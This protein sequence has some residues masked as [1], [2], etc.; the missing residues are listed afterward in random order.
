MLKNRRIVLV[1]DDEIMGASLLQRLQLEGAHVLWLK[2]M[3]RALG[4][5]RTPSVPIDAVICDIGLPDGSG[6]E[7]FTTLCQTR[8]PPPFLFI[9]GQGGIGQ[10]VR[11][12]RAGAADY[13]T[14][15]FDMAMFLERL[16]LLLS[17]RETIEFP[18]LLGVSAA[19]R[20]IDALIARAATMEAPV[21]IR[22]GAGTG[23]DLIARRIHELG[24]KGSPDF[25]S[26][27]LGRVEDPLQALR[28]G[29]DA[30][31]G[32]TLFVNALSMLPP[33]GQ[34]L[35]LA[36]LAEVRLIAACGT[37]LEALVADGRLDAELLYRPGWLEIPVPPLKTRPEDAVWLLH[38][39]FQ[40]LAPDKG[41]AR[42]IGALCDAAV[43]QH[44]WP[45]GG[46]EV[47]S[48]LLRALAMAEGDT[49]QPSDLFPERRASDDM[50]T[51][52]EARDAAE[53][54]Q[55]I[56]A[57][58]RTQGQIGE[59]ARLLRISRTTLW[60]KMQRFNLS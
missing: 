6:E 36:R 42:T 56:A 11:L 28:T 14:K 44:D 12:I 9:T 18:T 35:L 20:Q 29:F 34:A 7:L 41:A 32:G 19:A 40:R 17:P 53:R 33:Q 38:Q 60:E 21:L 26:V 27:N 48:R 54:Q 31:A 13:V 47:R 49:L 59:A 39:L 57:L 30:A 1:E 23:K 24:S 25:V 37:D 22:G 51:L 10:A 43:R 16:S 50:P 58:E 8:T 45:G 4:A 2:Q 5:I 15:P 3:V 46:R 52:A 55:I